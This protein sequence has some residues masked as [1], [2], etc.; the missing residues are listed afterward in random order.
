[1]TV[2]FS[3]NPYL[4]YSFITEELE[5]LLSPGSFASRMRE[6][7]AETLH[8]RFMEWDEEE[9]FFSK[10]DPV[11]T[12]YVWATKKEG[13][14]PEWLA[15]EDGSYIDDQG[16]MIPEDIEKTYTAVEQLAVYG[17]YLINESHMTEFGSGIGL[18]VQGM[19]KSGFNI[20]HVIEH[21]AESMLLAYQAIVYI[22]RIINND[23]LSTE[24]ANKLQTVDFSKLGQ[25]GAL[26]RHAP[27]S[28]LRKWAII[29][30]KQE[31]WDSA[32]KAAHALK[33]EIIIYG[34]TIN[35]ILSNENA[36]RTIAEWF[37]KAD[38]NLSG[39]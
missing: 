38:K 15:E 10:I 37:R 18:D 30:Y 29:R 8:Y 20:S 36:Q 31:V 21:Q 28:A 23:P 27:M 33:D 7:I 14:D 16:N 13:L 24:E 4:H 25:K 6:S 22:K 2:M 32:N 17:L 12:L 9:C 5:K 1:M 3:I 19:N 34:K 35:A 39:G 26:M 11:G